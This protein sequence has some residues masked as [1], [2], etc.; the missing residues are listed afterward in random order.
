M[1][2][3]LVDG[4]LGKKSGEGV[5]VMEKPGRQD[6]RGM[7]SLGHEPC[8]VNAMSESMYECMGI[9]EWSWWEGTAEWCGR[10]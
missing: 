9:G 7:G 10:A 8:R 1:D 5:A 2:T 4:A 3:W 6:G